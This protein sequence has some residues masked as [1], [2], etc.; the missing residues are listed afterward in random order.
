MGSSVGQNLMSLTPT[1]ES[2]PVAEVWTAIERIWRLEDARQYA[3]S[4]PL[5]IEFALKHGLT[6][7]TFRENLWAFLNDIFSVDP[8]L[9]SQLATAIKGNDSEFRR[10]LHFYQTNLRQHHRRSELTILT[11]Y[12]DSFNEHRQVFAYVRTGAPLPKSAKATSTDFQT[13]KSFYA[14]A[15]EFFASQLCILTCL[16]NIL[17]GR[18]FDQL[19]NIALAKYLETDKAKR[20]QSIANNNEFAMFIKEFDSNIRNASAHNW[21]FLKQDNA[22]IEYRSGGTGALNELS[23]TDYLYKCGNLMRQICNLMILELELDQIACD[24]AV[25]SR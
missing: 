4:G 24:L 5:N 10:F 20:P 8:S 16:N 22:T 1:K 21:F 15:F 12:F 9:R 7:H 13:V 19:K 6:Q 25:V 23:Y 17:D 3:L 2:Y 14:H 11:E 18:K